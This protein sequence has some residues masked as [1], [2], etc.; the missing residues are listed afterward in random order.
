MEPDGDRGSQAGDELRR[1]CGLRFGQRGGPGEL[2]VSAMSVALPPVG[3]VAVQID[4]VRVLPRV[5]GDTVR[6]EIGDENQLH[7]RHGGSGRA[8]GLDDGKASCL[9]PMDHSEDEDPGRG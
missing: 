3:E 8:Q 7:A 4:P 1:G 2:L 6:V 5:L 9:V